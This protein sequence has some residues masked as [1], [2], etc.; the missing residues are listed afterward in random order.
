MTVTQK[1]ADLIPAQRRH[2]ILELIRRK[3]VISVHE[4]AQ[5]TEA[6]L[7]TIRRDLDWLARAGAIQRSHGGASLKTAP[8]TTFEPDYHITSR[9]A[10]EEKS[11]IG[12][13]AADRLRNGQSVIFDSSS[14]V[15][16]AAYR[17]VEKGLSLTAI[18]NDL[19]IGELLAGCPSIRLL[20][21]GGTL[22]PGSYT[23]FGEPGTSFL[24]DLHVDVALMGIHAIT[25]DSSCC[26]TSLDIAYTKRH[27]V[28]AAGSVMI[29]ADAT[30]FDHVAF[31]H[32]FDIDDRFEIITDRPL[33]AAI[34]NN[35]ADRG[36]P[37]IVAAPCRT[38]AT[39]TPPGGLQH[40]NHLHPKQRTN[41]GGHRFEEKTDQI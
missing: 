25:A 6:S 15:Y 16:E 40:H 17:V 14:T 4:L 29:L 26:D 27:M 31:Y 24:R 10:R 23:L 3:G 30:K 21:S 41:P 9:I 18:T 5:S 1:K 22:R 11:Q 28:A 33:P 35:L 39:E 32:A 2:L 38:A 7:P 8:G 19:R 13:C 12:R 36:A 20:I 37:V 34:L